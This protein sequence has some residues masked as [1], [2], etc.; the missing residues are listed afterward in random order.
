VDSNNRK[1]Q[2]NKQSEGYRV[3]QRIIKQLQQNER[4]LAQQLQQVP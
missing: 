4:I 3:Q 1:P 2:Q